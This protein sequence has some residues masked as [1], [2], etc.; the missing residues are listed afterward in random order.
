MNIKY[1]LDLIAKKSNS[2][3][4]LNDNILKIILKQSNIH[5]K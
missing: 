1:Y 4:E 3:R 2:K 5:L